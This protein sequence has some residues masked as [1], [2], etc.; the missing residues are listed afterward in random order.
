MFIN[1]K[2]TAEK[3]KT[4]KAGIGTKPNSRFRLNT[5]DFTV[6]TDRNDKLLSSDI[7]KVYKNLQFVAGVIGCN[8][9]DLEFEYDHEQS[10]HEIATHSIDLN[11]RIA[12]GNYCRKGDEIVLITDFKDGV[13][14]YR[15]FSGN[16]FMAGRSYLSEVEWDE[17]F[18]VRD[19]V[20]LY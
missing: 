4:L 8:V 1:E 10:D 18:L 2:I 11:N 12:V 13:Y 17:V 5:I 20:E 7:A 3:F 14:T 15:T 9:D 6:S 19:N 16:E